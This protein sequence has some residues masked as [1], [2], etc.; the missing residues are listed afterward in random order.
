MP[1]L[2]YLTERRPTFFSSTAFFARAPPPLPVQP[3][4]AMAASLYPTQYI[5]ANC[6]ICTLRCQLGPRPSL[7]LHQSC[8]LFSPDPR[9]ARISEMLQRWPHESARTMSSS[10]FPDLL[11]RSPFYQA[12]SKHF[13]AFAHFVGISTFATDSDTTGKRGKSQLDGSSRLAEAEFMARARRTRTADALVSG[14]FVHSYLYSHRER[15]ASLSEGPHV[16]GSYEK[17]PRWLDSG[18]R[19]RAVASRR[20]ARCTRCC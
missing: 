1:C 15:D 11:L 9:C 3:M 8:K 12:S 16:E 14:P 4:S 7:S 19:G 5:V 6:P 13:V 10:S 2:T 17:R 18:V 20:N